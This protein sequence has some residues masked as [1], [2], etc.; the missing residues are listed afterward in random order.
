MSLWVYF[1]HRGPWELGM[2]VD[3]PHIWLRA[4]ISI[5]AGA[6]WDSFFHII[7]SSAFW[8][9]HAAIRPGKLVDG[10][11]VL[12]SLL[13][14][15]QHLVGVLRMKKRQGWIMGCVSGI[16]RTIHTLLEVYEVIGHV[17]GVCKIPCGY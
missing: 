1:V 2:L 3:T 11:L 15:P 14:R 5:I 9:L 6:L 13:G 16:F 12:G 7:S 8:H 10:V 4:Y 17:A